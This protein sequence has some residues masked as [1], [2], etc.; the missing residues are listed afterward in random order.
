MPKFDFGADDLQ[1]VGRLLEQFLDVRQ[2]QHA[3]VPLADG[4]LADRRHDGRLAAGGRHHGARV[5]V[6]RAAGARRRRL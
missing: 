2:D 5:V 6:A 4:V 3:A 1:L